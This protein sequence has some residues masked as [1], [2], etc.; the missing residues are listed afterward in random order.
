M[1]AYQI[2]CLLSRREVEVARLADRGYTNAQIAD[3]LYISVATIKRHLA[4]V[5]EKLGITSRRD[6]RDRL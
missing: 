5:F 6:L 3:E 2:I 1:E 4:T